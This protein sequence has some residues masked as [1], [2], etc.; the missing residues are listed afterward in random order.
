MQHEI[1]PNSATPL[2][3]RTLTVLPHWIDQRGTMGDSWYLFCAS[4]TTDA[5]LPLI[6]VTLDYVKSGYSYYAV[7]TQITKFGLARA[8][9][10]LTCALQILMYDKKRLQFL[11]TVMRHGEMIAAI[12]QM[13]VHVDIN[14]A[15][16]CP[17]PQSI[18][19]KVK[20]YGD[21]HEKLPVPEFAGRYVGK[22]DPRL[23]V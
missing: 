21:A 3:L 10:E 14:A 20:S 8:G 11:T 16:S 23:V 7:E 9:D 15:K 4:E 22:G 18:F 19:E 6:G 1:Q 2:E 13:Y 5:F 12:E 17:A